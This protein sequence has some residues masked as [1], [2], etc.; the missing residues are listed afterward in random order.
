ML[1]Y[2]NEIE[3]RG[4]PPSGPKMRIL[5]IAYACSPMRGG[6]HLL[7]WEWASRLAER[8][9]VVVLTTGGRIKESVGQR[10]ASL[11]MVPVP[12]GA[13]RWLKRTGYLGWHLYYR[14]WHIAAA[15]LGRRLLAERRFDIVHQ[16]T[17]HTVR[18][19]V[20]LAR[21]DAPP[22]V[23]GPIGGLE[24]IPFRMLSAL[25][26]GGFFEIIRAISNWAV[27]RLP[28]IRRTAR[29]AAAILVSNHDT[30]RRLPLVDR[31]KLI[32]MPANA[33][34]L[35][36]LRPYSAEGSVLVLIA[37]GTIVRMRAFPLVFQAL[38]A[39][40]VERRRRIRLTF[41]GRGPDEQRLRRMVRKI[42]L[43]DTVSFAGLV[44]R[45]ATL[46]A[47][48]R[49]HLLVFPSLRDS[50]SSSVAEAM[51]IGLPT[52]ALDLAGPRAMLSNGGGFLIPAH[53]PKQT[54]STIK[55]VLGALLDDR[56]PLYAE[57]HR[58]VEMARV[59]FSWEHRIAR[60]EELC[61]AA[62]PISNPGAW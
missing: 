48:S 24:Q 54:I 22:F 1:S 49:A 35:R 4:P 18:V 13:F 62:T 52:L 11:E 5:M 27:P 43:S 38:A 26:P 23:W 25:G 2:S 29:N 21:A 8:H 56:R 55:H 59:L 34:D 20:G 53:T 51:A 10:P 17:F 60:Y 9:A 37:V 46:E 45:P 14:L 41:L 33:V 3:R 30:M 6:E 40:P 15:R 7:G 58:A 47:M 32:Y 19:P 28:A 39:M 57:S 44:S 50:G 42:H 31:G 61:Y 16:C 36:P 12:D